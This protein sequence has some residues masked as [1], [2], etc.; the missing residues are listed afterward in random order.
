MSV[1]KVILVGRLGN[2][3]DVNFMKNGDAVTNFSVATSKRW[4]D[5]V[6]KERHEDT[7]WHRV[8][9]FGK[10]AETAAELLGKGKQVYVEGSLR[11]RKWKD[12]NGHDRYTTEVLAHTIQLVANG[13]SPA[14][15]PA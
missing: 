8:S 14:D 9:C 6:T 5:K 10:V 15:A 4:T 2:A 12:K 1:N 3:P 7:E 13:K 11:T